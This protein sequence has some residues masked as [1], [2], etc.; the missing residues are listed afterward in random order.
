MEMQMNF[1]LEQ[2]TGIEIEEI[3]R[4]YILKKRVI[5]RL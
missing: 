5:I 3:L 4:R 2:E 1:K